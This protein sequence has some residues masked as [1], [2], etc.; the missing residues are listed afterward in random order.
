MRTARV[1]AASHDGRESQA[2]A[3]VRAHEHLEGERDV[4]LAHPRRERASYVI[5]GQIRE[6]RRALDRC[7]LGLV[8]DG[9]K[10]LDHVLGDN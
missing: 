10:V 7:D 5:E 8:L 4:D 2:L 1:R 3:A 6:G 9:A